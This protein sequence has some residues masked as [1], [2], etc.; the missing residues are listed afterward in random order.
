MKL[1]D[2]E[3]MSGQVELNP[4]YMFQETALPYV[5]ILN[6][7]FIREHGKGY[8]V[9]GQPIIEGPFLT[10]FD[11]YDDTGERADEDNGRKVYHDMSKLV[12]SNY[13][14]DLLS[15]LEET[16]QVDLDDANGELEPLL[17]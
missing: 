5:N 6:T 10:Y 13:L 1:Q 15:V 7:W 2:E 8:V 16:K 12:V 4:T 3:R 11:I 9:V 14:E 17:P